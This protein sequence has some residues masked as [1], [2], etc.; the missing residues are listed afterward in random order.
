MNR[1]TYRNAFDEIPFS[2]DFQARTMELLRRHATGSEKEK[3]R[4]R[5]GRTKKLAAL[6]AAA[7][8]VLMVSVSAANPEAI[9]EIVWELKTAFFVSGTTE[10]GSFAAIRVPEVTLMDREDRV[11]LTIEGEETDVTDAL[12]AEGCYS[13]E[14]TEKDGRILIEVTGTPEDCACTITG[15]QADLEKP[16]FTVTREK[17]EPLADADVSYSVAEESV[18]SEETI[19]IDGSTLSNV[20]TVT[21]TKDDEFVTG[22]YDG[23][24]IYGLV[25]D[26]PMP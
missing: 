18:V 1:K 23:E 10:D 8:A 5:I 20:K 11:I 3:K 16:M 2:P 14:Q 13:V 17:N 7:A 25:T 12:E 9:R 26:D 15:Y 22:H 21:L 4:M 6:L 19:E 24:D